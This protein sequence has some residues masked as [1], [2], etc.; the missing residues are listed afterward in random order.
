M[1]TIGSFR[2]AGGRRFAAVLLAAPLLFGAARAEEPKIITIVV[3]YPAG[4]LGDILPRVMANVLAEQTGHTFIVD[5]KPGATQMIGTRAAA[6]ATPDGSTVLFGS[7]TS[8]AI[9]PSL[10]RHLDYDPV[11]DFAPVSLSFVTPMYLVT[12]PGLPV[13]SVQDLIALARREPGKLTYASGGVG[14]SSHLAGEL[15]KTMTGID[16]THVPYAG[17]GPAV[18]DV[19][20]GY[21]DMTITASGVSYGDQV[22]ILGVTGA[23][24]TA[25]APN[26]P[27]IAESGVPGYEATIWFGFLAPAGTPADVVEELSAQM[28]KA[29][30]SPELRDKLQATGNDIELVGSTPKEFADFIGKEIPRWR[31]VIEAAHIEQQ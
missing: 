22:K 12:R 1:T 24:R 17:T 29:A 14:S 2:R 31:T 23:K 7:V 13:N 11:K 5:N 8:L 18:R 16:I 26:V 20:G 25:E 27:T 30:A 9:N 21:V 3:P 28:R 10:K 4:G 19:I 6:R 15:L